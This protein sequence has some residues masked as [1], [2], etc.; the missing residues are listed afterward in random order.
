MRL[1]AAVME[2]AK[3]VCTDE[4]QNWREMWAA[5]GGSLHTSTAVHVWA[6]K[7]ANNSERW[8]RS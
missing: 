6:H 3:T 1:E 4:A 2:A 5:D 7:T 8:Q